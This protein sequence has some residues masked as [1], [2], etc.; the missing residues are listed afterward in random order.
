[1]SGGL[2]NGDLGVTLALNDAQVW[3]LNAQVWEWS[4]WLIGPPLLLWALWIRSRPSVRDQRRAGE[5][6]E[7][8]SPAEPIGLSRDRDHAQ[9]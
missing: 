7:G 6:A 9:G 2:T 8:T 5:L 1:V 4:L 3:S